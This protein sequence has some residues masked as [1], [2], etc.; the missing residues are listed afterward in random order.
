M[1]FIVFFPSK[2]AKKGSMDLTRASAVSSKIQTPCRPFLTRQANLLRS[3]LTYGS[4][5]LM[6]HS[7]LLHPA[8][9][10]SVSSNNH[11][12]GFRCRKL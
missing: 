2:P 9:N 4:P 10:L 3:L 7:P 11:N 6:H 5:S 1:P 8:G 12:L